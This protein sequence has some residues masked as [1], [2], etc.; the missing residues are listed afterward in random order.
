MNTNTKKTGFRINVVDILIVIAVIACI[1]AVASRTGVAQKFFEPAPDQ[2]AEVRFSISA[3]DQ[4][5][6]DELQDTVGSNITIDDGGAEFGTLMY[7]EQKPAAV[8]IEDSMGVIQKMEHMSLRDV[9]GTIAVKG[10]T[11]SDG[12]YING[13][14]W[15]GV[16]KTYLVNTPTQSFSFTV[17][18]ISIA[19]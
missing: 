10:A 5:V 15:V 6:A 16:G 4:Y 1:I 14:T 9:E 8:Y 2:T 19:E 17:I 7:A 12:F 11:K 3:V 18:G 13:E